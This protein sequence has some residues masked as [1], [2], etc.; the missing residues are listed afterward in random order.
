MDPTNAMEPLYHLLE[1]IQSEVSK[2]SP[3]D[4]TNEFNRMI[5]SPLL[6][7]PFVTDELKQKL[8]P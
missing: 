7:M 5:A 2:F 3:I 4:S 1:K 6:M 8:P